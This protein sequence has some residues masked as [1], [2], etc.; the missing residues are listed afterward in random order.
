MP[1]RAGRPD[2]GDLARIDANRRPAQ[3]G[4]TPVRWIDS[5][6]EPLRVRGLACG[7]GCAHRS[8]LSG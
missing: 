8:V 5:R 3:L 7:S 6:E 4:E 2:D 1:G